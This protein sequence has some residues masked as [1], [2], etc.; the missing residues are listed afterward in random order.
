MRY[1][2]NVTH[3]RYGTRIHPAPREIFA[4]AA[5]AA[6]IASQSET[7]AMNPGNGE[8]D[9]KKMTDQRTFKTSWIAKMPIAS[10]LSAVPFLFFQ[11]RKSAMPI[12][13]YKIVHT[14][15]KTHAGGVRA[16]FARNAYH[17]PIFGVV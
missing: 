3:R 12:K 11:T 2:A 9:P 14:G 6:M 7:I 4:K 5:I 16:G 8:C 13:R 15:P 1:A 17:V 10:F